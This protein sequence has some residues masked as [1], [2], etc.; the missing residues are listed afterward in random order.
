MNQQIT[1]TV[2]E[3]QFNPS[4]IVSMIWFVC[5][6]VVD[7]IWFEEEYYS[8]FVEKKKNKILARLRDSMENT[9]TDV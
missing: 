7:V 1:A 3:E 8:A 2:H 4:R 5:N 9:E 6:R